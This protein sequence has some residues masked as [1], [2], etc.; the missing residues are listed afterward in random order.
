MKQRGKMLVLESE[1]AESS[2]SFFL[3]GSVKR[4]GEILKLP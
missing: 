1:R 3:T 4:L 2:K